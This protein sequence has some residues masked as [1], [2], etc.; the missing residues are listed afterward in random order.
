M[1]EHQG[2][3]NRIR[4]I[5]LLALLYLSATSCAFVTSAL[6]ANLPA[7]GNYVSAGLGMECKYRTE[8]QPYW[9]IEDLPEPERVIT[10]WHPPNDGDSRLLTLL[11]FQFYDSIEVVAVRR[12]LRE[13]EYSNFKAIETKIKWS[14]EYEYDGRVFEREMRWGNFLWL[15]LVRAALYNLVAF[16]LD[17][18]CRLTS[19]VALLYLLATFCAWLTFLAAVALSWWQFPA[20]D[21][22]ED[23]PEPEIVVEDWHSPTY[24]DNRLAGFVV[25]EFPGIIAV[26]QVIRKS[27]YHD[28]HVF[29][30]QVDESRKGITPIYD[31][32]QID[33]R[34]R[35]P[36][37]LRLFLILTLLYNLAVFRLVMVYR[38]K[39]H[40]KSA[41]G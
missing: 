6:T 33:R 25:T 8:I 22:Y 9:H 32:F 24:S 23:I 4:R 35:W 20:S 40:L 16:G 12:V 11:G 5:F 15:F 36:S 19:R 34:I 27:R 38:R 37:A 29:E 18:I 41:S 10:D 2:R 28:I 7:A 30:E 21:S 31:G 13:S 3:Q 26:R 39:K 1:T 14:G 17:M